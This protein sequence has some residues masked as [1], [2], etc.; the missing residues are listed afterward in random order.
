M[1]K[2]LKIYIKT[3]GCKI[4]S[5][6]SGVLEKQ[7]AEKKYEITEAVKEA[8]VAIINSC[9][10]TENA[11]KDA[12]YLLRRYGRENPNLFK[13]IT[14]CYAQTSAAKVSNLEEVD[15]IATNELKDKISSLLGLRYQQWLEKD[16]APEAYKKLELP[17]EDKKPTHFKSNAVFFDHYRSN[18]TRAY[19]KI[20]DGC[21]NFCTYCQIPFARGKS[22]SVEKSRLISEISTLVKKGVPEVVLAGIDIGDYG[23]EVG[24][25]YEPEDIP[26]LDLLKDIFSISGL[27][28]LRMSSIEPSDVSEAMLEIF[29]QNAHIFC[30]HFH[31]PLQS[32]CDRILK[33][34]SRSYNTEKFY[35]NVTLIRK[36]F[37]KAMITADIIPGFPGE[38]QED[39]EETL[40]FIKKCDLNSLHVFPYSKRPYTVAARMPEQLDPRL[41]KERAYTLRQYQKS[42]E[43]A[44]AKKFVNCELE[45]LWEEKKDKL[46]RLQGKSKNYLP[47]VL[48]S[49]AQHAVSVGTVSRVLVKGMLQDRQLLAV[50]LS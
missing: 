18:K 4:N 49:Q 33:R 48:A 20:Q 16:K 1:S 17:A 36:F 6:D 27:K 46:G 9:S 45:V 47:V 34:M 22:V 21:N 3:L 24:K 38:S 32:G 30:D 14:G 37:P 29:A 10:V 23:R 2:S 13:V 26:M 39:F 50:A 31:L 8:H 5:F 42:A 7:L 25:H 19:L 11:E 40:E 15:W 43:H 44:Y 35:E 28:R 41:I 12:R